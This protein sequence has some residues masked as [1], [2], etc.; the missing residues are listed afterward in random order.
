GAVRRD[1]R[2]D[3][4]RQLLALEVLLQKRLRVLAERLRIDRLQDRLVQGDQ[5]RLRRIEAAVEEHRADDRLDG[6]AEDRRAAKAAALGFALA[7]QQ[8]RAQAEA[9]CDLDERLLL[10]EVRTQARKI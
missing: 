10:D 5:H 6:V 7:E 3:R 1:D 2:I 8:V 4:Q 9:L